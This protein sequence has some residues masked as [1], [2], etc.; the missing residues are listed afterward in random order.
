MESPLI[1]V[2]MPTYNCGNYIAQAIN[3]VINQ[4]HTNIELIVVD[5]GSTDNTL[6]IVALASRNVSNPKIIYIPQ[7]NKGAA[8]ARNR[9][10]AEAKGEYIAF[11]DAD[12][13]LHK[14]W[15]A[16]ALQALADNNA[17]VVSSNFCFID[18]D[19]N[20]P[21]VNP[22]TEDMPIW[23]NYYEMQYSVR[24]S[25]FKVA[26]AQYLKACPHDESLTFAEDYDV[27]LRMLKMGAKWLFMKYPY[28]YYRLRKNSTCHTYNKDI[29]RVLWRIHRKHIDKVGR[30][31]AWLYY[32]KH[33]GNYR[34]GFLLKAL[35]ARNIGKIIK[36]GFIAMRSPS[37]IFSV[38][39]FVITRILPKYT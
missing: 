17:D 34:W 2:I 3:S 36:H 37:R 33:L 23:L 16:V 5:D 25:I 12:D 30:L 26:K 8:A 13:Y 32:R 9:A 4:T 14:G 20:N 10:I 24:P 39:R 19:G 1:S 6:E 38:P 35:K 15:F 22:C 18:E 29:A 21:Q 7:A 11:L 31:N 27:W 28:A